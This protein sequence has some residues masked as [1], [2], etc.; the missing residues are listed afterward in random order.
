[1]HQPWNGW[2]ETD[3]RTLTYITTTRTITYTYDPPGRL[4]DADYSTGESYAYVYDARR[5]FRSPGNR[6]AYTVTAPA[7]S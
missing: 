3:F 1:V 4:T 5:P 6:T 2:T 7:L